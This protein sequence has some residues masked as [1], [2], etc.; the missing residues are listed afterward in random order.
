LLPAAVW[1]IASLQGSL[2]SAMCDFIQVLIPPV[3]GSIPAHSFVTS[4]LHTFPDTAT[5]DD[6]QCKTV[7]LDC[8]LPEQLDDIDW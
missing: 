5:K 1:D 6:P 3:P 4:A 8:G 7:G 2:T